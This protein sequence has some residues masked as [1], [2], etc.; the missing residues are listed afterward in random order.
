MK[1]MQTLG[2]PYTDAE[3]TNAKKS[4]TITI[5]KIEDNLHADPDFVKSYED[6][7]KKAAARGEEFVPMRQREIVALIAYIQRLGTDIK[8]KDKV[9]FV[10][11]RL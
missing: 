5:S 9:I 3:V 2:V 1:V 4:N 6:S 10:G 11:S 8:V 7:K